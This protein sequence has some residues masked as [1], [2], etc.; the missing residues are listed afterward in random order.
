MDIILK[1]AKEKAVLNYHPWIF[2]GAIHNIPKGVK[3]G[4]TVKIISQSGDF[5]GY[6]HY[7]PES[8]IRVRLISFEESKSDLDP[9]FWAERWAGIYRKKLALFDPS[10]TNGFRFLFSEGDLS[11]GFT[12]DIYHRTAVIQC[13]TP[14]SQKH[15]AEL[16]YFLE[17]QK[18]E[19]IIEKQEKSDS[20]EESQVIFHKGKE[21]RSHF[22]ENGLHF[23]VDVVTGQKTGFFLDQRDNRML[24]A[25]YAKDKT[26]LNTFGYSGA[27]SVYALH[28]SARLVHTLDISKSALALCEENLLQNFENRV[29]TEKHKSLALD[30]FDYLKHMEDGFYDLIVL[31]PPAFTKRIANVQAAARGY[32]DINLRAISKIKPGGL[33]FTFSCSQHISADLFRK[34]VFGAAKDA[35][36][37]VRVLHQLSQAPDHAF[38]IYHPEGEYLKGL[39]IQVD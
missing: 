19:S 22:K 9:G 25:S 39:V 32:K 27:F 31:D 30:C 18:F 4:D 24:L 6:G 1:K 26:V 28:S 33:I 14:G 35:G 12:V 8:Q 23:V 17:N 36:R 10:V 20:I 34:I 3:T 29:I 38:S 7:D 16:I 13:K 37:N 2:S 5:L 11:P 15:K 21:G